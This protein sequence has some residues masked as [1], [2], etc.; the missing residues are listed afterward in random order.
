M[1]KTD[2][3]FS[4]ELSDKQ[5]EDIDMYILS[6]IK[7]E[8][9]DQ[10]QAREFFERESDAVAE[11]FQ[12]YLEKEISWFDY[13]YATAILDQIDEVIEFLAEDVEIIEV[14][15]TE[16]EDDAIHYTEDEIVFVEVSVID[17]EDDTH[18]YNEN[19]IDWNKLDDDED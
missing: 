2:L 12:E 11:F 8:D 16:T 7:V 1:K 19:E 18:Y 14:G 5:C 4:E 13:K 17:T 10:Y 3:N 15:V 9:F 6:F